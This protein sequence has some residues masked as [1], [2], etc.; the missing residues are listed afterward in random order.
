MKISRIIEGI[1][2]IDFVSLISNL[3]IFT[4]VMC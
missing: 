4:N 3:S 2:H 1:L